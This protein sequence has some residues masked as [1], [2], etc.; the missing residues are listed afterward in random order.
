MVTCSWAAVSGHLQGDGLTWMALSPGHFLWVLPGEMELAG[1]LGEAAPL[2][3]TTQDHLS[4]G[5]YS[6]DHCTVAY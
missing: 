3:P 2:V 1:L 6:S 4:V 5:G